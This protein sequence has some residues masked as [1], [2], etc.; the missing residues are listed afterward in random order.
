MFVGFSLRIVEQC[1]HK[2]YERRKLEAMDAILEG[3]AVSE[4]LESFDNSPS[5][6]TY[7]NLDADVIRTKHSD[8]IDVLIAK[9]KK[10]P[11]Q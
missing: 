1:T 10:R 2:E 8:G 5:T 11:K 6:R 7:S 4:I 9:R 3:G